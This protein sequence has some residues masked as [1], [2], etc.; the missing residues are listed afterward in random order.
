LFSNN[1]FLYSQNMEP[2][3]MKKQKNL[4]RIQLDQSGNYSNHFLQ[5]MYS[6]V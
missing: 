3:T 5:V 4:N 6:I 2:A 1:Y